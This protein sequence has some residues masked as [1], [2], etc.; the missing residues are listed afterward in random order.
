M[1]VAIDSHFGFDLTL[2]QARGC[3]ARNC[4][5]HVAATRLYIV[6]SSVTSPVGTKQ[7]VNE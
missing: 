1:H 2:A 5:L 3:T 6:I 4:G 7:N